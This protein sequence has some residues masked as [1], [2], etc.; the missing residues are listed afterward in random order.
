MRH[1]MLLAVLLVSVIVCS[2]ISAFPQEGNPGYHILD[3]LLLGGEGGWDYL[4]VDASAHRVYISRSSHVQVVDTRT[5]R[6][7]GDIPQTIGVH[8]VALVPGLTKGY[9]S[10]GRDSSVTVFDLNTLKEIAKIHIDAR[11]PDA[12]LYEP[13]SR[14]V[15]TFNGGS[16]NVTA[17]DPATD[18]VVGTL[19]VGGKPEYVGYDGKGHVY[20]NIEDRSKV[21]GFDARTLKVLSSW[22]I[23]PGEEP[24]GLAIDRKDGLL[25]S[26][27]RNERMVI[28]NYASGKVVG[29]VPIGA[30][31]DGAAYDPETNLA[32]SSNGAGTM[33]VVHVDGPEKFSVVETISTRRGART[34][35][36]DETTHRLYTISAKF[37]P[38]SGGEHE[39]PRPEPGSAT[40]YVIGK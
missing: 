9:T 13:V 38:A 15:F 12:I 18:N 39:R 3:T 33:T 30:G 40:L 19:P 34:C 23:A 14:R 28:S 27:C 6:L 2:P 24:S 4:T 36:L 1:L 10:N 11:N 21:L 32:F 22:S 7:I 35:A 8:G 25:F 29:E 31:V 17:I 26:V 20:V 16:A 37:Q 5:M